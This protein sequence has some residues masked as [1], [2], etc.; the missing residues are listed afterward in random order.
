ME[1]GWVTTRMIICT[2]SLGGTVRVCHSEMLLCFTSCLTENV[3][4]S[5]FTVVPCCNDSI[6]LPIALNSSYFHLTYFLSWH[7]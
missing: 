6:T 7:V 1:K 5:L 3:A 2:V 4:L